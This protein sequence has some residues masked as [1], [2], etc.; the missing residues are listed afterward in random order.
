MNT[1]ID[2]GHVAVQ[3]LLQQD[4]NS[5]GV[6]VSMLRLDQIHPVISGNKYLKLLPFLKSYY[7]GNFVGIESYGGPYSNHL[8]ALAYSC[9]LQQI[10]CT[11]YIRGREVDNHTL[12]DCQNWGMELTF[13]NKAQ[14]DDIAYHGTS[15]DGALVIPM[16]GN[17]EDG[18]FGIEQVLPTD[19]SPYTHF[20]CS[21][22][23]GTTLRGL[24]RVVK[25]KFA[26]L[27]VMAMRDLALHQALSDIA[28]VD[29]EH[30]L[31]GFGKAN[32]ELLE[33]I[34]SFYKQHGIVLDVVYT[35]KMMRALQH[36]I[37]ANYFSAGAHLLVLHTGGLQGNRSY[38]CIAALA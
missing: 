26:T 19:M 38:E 30:Y 8:H 1:A 31:P 12:R 37:A 6:R 36:K 35:A 16:G 15:S 21:V 33:F 10:P 24:A 22:G 25:N 3:E 13:L 20:C 4:W 17:D 29:D 7:E 27:G 5:K 14:F 9:F 18:L 23:T 2:I 11:G 32:D 34:S 28:I